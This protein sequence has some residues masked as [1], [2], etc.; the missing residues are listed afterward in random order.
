MTKINS[1][2]PQNFH[3]IFLMHRFMIFKRS[4]QYA[5]FFVSVYML[6]FA[7]STTSVCWLFPP[8]PSPHTLSNAEAVWSPSMLGC[9]FSLSWY[10]G[11]GTDLEDSSPCIGGL[12][13]HIK[14]GGKS[15]WENRGQDFDFSLCSIQA[16]WSCWKTFFFSYCFCPVKQPLLKFTHKS[17]ETMLLL[18]RYHIVRFVFQL[19]VFGLQK[20]VLTVRGPSCNFTV[21]TFQLKGSLDK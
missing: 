9:H 3:Y 12:R 7:A 19:R 15:S 11:C 13:T 8:T 6:L 4:V 10:L 14:G 18:K 21:V 2:P 5:N 17:K 20:L 16:L 1:N